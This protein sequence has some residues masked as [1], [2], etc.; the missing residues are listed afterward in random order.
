MDTT[1][2]VDP[3]APAEPRNG[4]PPKLN[5]PPSDAASQ[6]AGGCDVDPTERVA[7]TPGDP[8]EHNAAVRTLPS[9]TRPKREQNHR[10]TAAFRSTPRGTP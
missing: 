9:T 3:L 8:T 6:Y 7:A 1:G 2:D 4:A 10:C 5:T